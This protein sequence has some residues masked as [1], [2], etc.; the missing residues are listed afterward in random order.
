[1]T[2]P[3]LIA[4]RGYTLHYPE[5]TLSAVR[6]AIEAGARYVEV[7]V[8]L[9]RDAVPVLFHDHTLKRLCG[10]DG[11]VHDLGLAELRELHPSD[12]DRFG[13]R[14]AA[15]PFPTLAGLAELIARHPSIMFFIEIKR[16]ALSRF[17][18]TKTVARILE[19]L[20]PVRRQCI[21]ISYSLTALRAVKAQGWP[22]LGAVI[23]RW[24]D[25]KRPGMRELAPRYLF[26]DADGLPR[27]GKLRYEGA[28]LAVFEV[29]SAAVAHK[30]SVRGA[31]LIETFHLGELKQALGHRLAAS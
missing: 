7:D 27:F 30:L 1:M 2:A 10:V 6:A 24:R 28:Q 8:Q 19:D 5:N 3:E 21:P 14:F 16:I 17:G 23:D 31:D 18:V 29:Q 26:C 15:E 13:Y 20:K 22:I 11:A 12:F 4:H 25:R 9:S